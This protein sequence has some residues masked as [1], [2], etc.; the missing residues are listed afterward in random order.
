MIFTWYFTVK[1]GECAQEKNAVEESSTWT[2]FCTWLFPAQEEQPHNECCGTHYYVSGAVLVFE[3]WWGV[4][5]TNGTLLLASRS[6]WSRAAQRVL[7]RHGCPKGERLLPSVLVHLHFSHVTSSRLQPLRVREPVPASIKVQYLCEGSQPSRSSSKHLQSSDRPSVLEK[8]TWR[9]R[10]ESR[11]SSQVDSPWTRL[12]CFEDLH[13]SAGQ[14]DLKEEKS[15]VYFYELTSGR[16]FYISDSASAATSKSTG[17]ILKCWL[18]V[19]LRL[20]NL[21]YWYDRKFRW[22]KPSCKIRLCVLFDSSGEAKFVTLHRC[23][24]ASAFTTSQ[25]VSLVVVAQK[26]TKLA[27]SRPPNCWFIYSLFSL[28]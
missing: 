14:Q 26:L 9:M 20:F 1:S 18:K 10:G 24:R 11:L 6:R 19:F 16:Y 23:R 5:G 28:A 3:S 2:T 7:A 21:I 17:Y 15:E 12:V 4:G 13:P 22:Q 27:W 25:R 8:K